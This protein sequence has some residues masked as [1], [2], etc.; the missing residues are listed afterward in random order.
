MQ[1]CCQQ[2]IATEDEAKERANVLLFVISDE[3]R[4]I[5]SLIEAAYS[6]SSG[7]RV[8]LAVTPVEN[9]NFSDRKEL[10]DGRT[11][12]IHLAKLFK[13]P[14]FDNISDAV[15]KTTSILKHD[16]VCAEK[17]INVPES[18]LNVIFRHGR[19]VRFER[20]SFSGALFDITDTD[21]CLETM[22]MVSFFA[23][24]LNYFS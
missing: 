10:T 1:H 20:K 6:I 5:S 19:V 14:C 24:C 4:S 12:L 16:A 23:N 11:I 21:R 17:R 8:V 9:G 13:I 2:L 15:Q 3:T 22:M 18:V 7:K